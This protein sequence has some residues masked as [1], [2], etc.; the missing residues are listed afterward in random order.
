MEQL[1]G[2]EPLSQEYLIR[3]APTVLLFGL[4]NAVETIGHLVAQRT[5]PFPV[6]DE[7]EEMTKYI[8]V[9]VHDL[10]TEETESPSTSDSSRVSHHPSHECFR[11]GTPKG[12]VESIHEEEATPTN[13]LNDEVKGDAATPPDLWVEH[14]KA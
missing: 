9:T 8:M 10:L 1:V 4:L 5:P 6:N 11:V 7:F 14:Q 3:S 2:G 12:H 13:D